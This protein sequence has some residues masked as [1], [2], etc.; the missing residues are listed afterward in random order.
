MK[1]G[2]ETLGRIEAVFN[3]IIKE[4]GRDGIDRYLRDELIIV[5]RP[6]L[7]LKNPNIPIS[8]RKDPFIVRDRFIVNTKEDAKPKISYLGNNFKEWFFGQIVAPRAAYAMKSAILKKSSLDEPI[9]KEL[10]QT[11][12]TDLAA[13][14]ELMVRQSD[15]QEGDLL[16][17]GY[18][19]IFYIRD[20]K[21][22]LRAVGAHWCY[23]GWYVGADPVS[24]PYEWFAGFSVLSLNS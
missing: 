21:G 6:N 18:A 4:A 19:N 8:E 9:I 14:F 7:E 5:K 13:I 16:T 3:K 15:G 2:D 10:G 12:E 11:A 22:V 20:A 23:D 24:D 17:N 1:Y